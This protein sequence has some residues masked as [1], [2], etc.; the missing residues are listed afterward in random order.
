[1]YLSRLAISIQAIRVVCE[2]LYIGYI[3]EDCRMI[4]IN[5]D[6]LN[7]SSN[8]LNYHSLGESGHS[9]RFL[10]FEPPLLFFSIFF[11]PLGLKKEE[12][13]AVRRVFLVY[14]KSLCL[15]PKELWKW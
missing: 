10:F 1:V 3:M 14:D 11:I 6:Y 4:M 8:L 7:L 15:K 2:R 12:K 9:W 5:Y 13:L